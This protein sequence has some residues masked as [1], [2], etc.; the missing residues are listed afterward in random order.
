[1]TDNNMTFD[2]QGWICPKCGAVLSPDTTFCPF[3]V[4][5]QSTVITRSGVGK[6]TVD[7]TPPQTYTIS[8]IRSNS[9]DK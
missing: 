2:R 9:N 5:K 6:Y 7:Y 1:M 3:C 4:P 8:E